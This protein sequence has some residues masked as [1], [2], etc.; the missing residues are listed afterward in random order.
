M[1]SFFKKLLEKHFLPPYYFIPSQPNFK[2]NDMK[3]IFFLRWALILTLFSYDLAAQTNENREPNTLRIMSYNI[4]DGRGMDG[5]T[6]YQRTADVINEVAPDVVAVQEVDSVTARSNQADV[7]RELAERT[8]M[9]RSYAPAI[10]YDG[11]K[12]G[13]GILSREKPLSV[14]HIP[15]PGREE[16]RTFLIAEFKDY[17][18][19]STHLSL[20]A[21]DQLLSLPVIKKEI[22]PLNKPVFIAGDLNATPGSK[23]IEALEKDFVI[24]NNPKQPTFP[25]DVPDS[26]L[27]Y[28]AFWKNGEKPFTLLRNRVV[29]A[30]EQSDH[31]PIVVDIRF[32][33]KPEAIF[34]TQ[35]YL[36]NPVGNGITVMWHTTVPVHS[37]VEYGTDTLNLT[38][39]NKLVNGQ[40]ISNNYLHKIRLDNLIPGQKYYYRVC[41]QEITLYSAYKKEFGETA[42]SDFSSFVLPPE[43]TTDFTAIIFN[44]LHN[45]PKTLAMLYDQVKDIPYDLVV[46]NGDIIDAPHTADQAISFISLVNRTLKANQIPIIYLRG[47]HEIRDAYSMDLKEQF[48]YIGGKTYCAFNWG[49]TRFVLLDCGEDKPDD[50]WVYYGLNDFTGLR[51]DETGFLKAEVTGKDFRQ[52]SRRV[53]IHHIPVYGN[54]D[55]YNP[56]RELW[57]GILSKA[58]FDISLNAH[59]HE[60][61]YLPKGKDGNNYPVVIGGGYNPNEATVM[62]LQKKKKEMTLKVLNTKGE[63]I[64]NLKL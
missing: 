34:R 32:K 21:E 9:F 6:D 28:I 15:L 5:M 46:C 3:N 13:I 53:I 36:Q 18:F 22:A 16:A 31:R 59:T 43:K 19:C 55:E 20:T 56:C 61:N 30:P 50:H 14:R 54:T 58:P 33:T 17:V 23:F 48:D 63:T 26:C 7:L 42:V 25:A 12:Y 44:D 11:G 2:C 4:R 38:K 51:A 27:D 39:K 10:D 49:D 40:I 60:F 64:L 62:V 8:L 29:N 45:T 41:S 35:P 52:A 24:L 1:K 47:N 37:W 57:G